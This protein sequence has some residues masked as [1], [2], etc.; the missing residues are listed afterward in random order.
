LYLVLQRLPHICEPCIH[1][2][3]AE[4]IRVADQIVHLFPSVEAAEDPGRAT[5]QL[6]VFR[7]T[8]NLWINGIVLHEGDLVVDGHCGP[9]QS[10][11]IETGLL[12]PITSQK[13]D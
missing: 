2:E 10:A 11:L 4:F 1:G 6:P 13:A 3:T 5:R 9:L 7:S 8:A 12:I